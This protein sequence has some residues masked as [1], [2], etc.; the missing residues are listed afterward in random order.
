MRSEK[1]QKAQRKVLSGIAKSFD[2]R[3]ETSSKFRFDS[4]LMIC[5]FKGI[6]LVIN[7]IQI[8]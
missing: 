2:G 1:R 7:K 4:Y 5:H 3:L 8:F 6:C